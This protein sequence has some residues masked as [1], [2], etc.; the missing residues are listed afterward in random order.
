MSIGLTPNRQAVNSSIGYSYTAHQELWDRGT[1]LTARYPDQH[2]QRFNV[3][4]R[5]DESHPAFVASQRLGSSPAY[6]A[7]DLGGPFDQTDLYFDFP[8]YGTGWSSGGI[9]DWRHVGPVI[10]HHGGFPTVQSGPSTRDWIDQTYFQPYLGIQSIPTREGLGGTAISRVAPKLSNGDFLTAIG[11]I[12]RE[13]IPSHLSKMSYAESRAEN[14]RALGSDYLNVEF[15]WLPLVSEIRGTAQ[16]IVNQDKI[17]QDLVRNSGR[18]TRRRYAFDT[19]EMTWVD[20]AGRYAQPWPQPGLHLMDQAGCSYTHTAQRRTWFAGEFRLRVPPELATA[21]GSVAEKAKHLLG[22]RI[23][24]DTLWNLAPWTWLADYVGNVGPVLG[25]L[26]S[27]QDGDLVMR[28]GYLMQ[29]AK[30]QTEVKHYG[31]TTAGGSFL[32]SEITGRVRVSRKT[33]LSASPFGFGLDWQGF[34]PRQ[35]AVLAALGI[36]RVRR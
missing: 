20:Q 17:L 7:L 24:P 6:R 10:A 28:Y 23:T 3:A 12:L 19:A 18:P 2:A 32:P 27:M 5:S 15:G 34:T 21:S 25:V 30:F 11:E 8:G 33:R 36:T 35:L 4:Y 22:L 29:E 14:I 9:A 1:Y 26:G 31:I 13:G 16:S